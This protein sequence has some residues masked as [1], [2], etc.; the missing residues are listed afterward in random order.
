MNLRA[1]LDILAATPKIRPAKP[2][3]KKSAIFTPNNQHSKQATGELHAEINKKKVSK[4]SLKTSLR[5]LVYR[6]RLQG[7]RDAAK[8]AGKFPGAGYKDRVAARANLRAAFSGK[9]IKSTTK[10]GVKS[11]SAYA[12]SKGRAQTIADFESRKAYYDG[13]NDVMAGSGAM[14]RWVCL[15]DSPCNDCQDNE[16]DG[17]IPMDE[18]FASGDPYPGQ[19]QN[20]Q[21]V[22]EVQK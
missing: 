9:S 17:F 18:V 13:V 11:G 22:L 15:G 10:K 2:K 19:H 3:K 21:C 7:A 4:D 16:D 5:R 1:H 12:T 14:K 6:S 20:C 8:Y